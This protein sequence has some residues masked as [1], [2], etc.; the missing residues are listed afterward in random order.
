[1]V[2][3]PY[4]PTYKRAI[5]QRLT[6]Q[7]K[8]QV[9]SCCVQ[10]GRFALCLFQLPLKFGKVDAAAA[11]NP[12]SATREGSRKP[13]MKLDTFWKCCESGFSKMDVLDFAIEIQALQLP[14]EDKWP[15]CARVN[16]HTFLRGLHTAWPC[17]M[18]PSDVVVRKSGWR[19][20][21]A[22]T[23]NVFFFLFYLVFVFFSPSKHLCV[24]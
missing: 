18:Q 19:N 2:K 13:L 15:A 3:N 5:N 20:S 4:R 21:C 12:T 14:C 8:S 1:M 22:A 11:S 24:N 17:H 9:A 6:R 7:T 23:K 10:T 16:L